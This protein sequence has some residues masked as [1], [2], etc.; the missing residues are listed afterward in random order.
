MNRWE[1]E[2][3]NTRGVLSLRMMREREREAKKRTGSEC[4]PVLKSL[5][6]KL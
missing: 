1:I 2:K 6:V 5:H 4:A 3:N